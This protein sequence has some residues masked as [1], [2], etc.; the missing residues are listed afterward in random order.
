V[1][2]STP[3]GAELAGRRLPQAQ[4][5]AWLSGARRAAPWPAGL[6]LLAFAADAATK[7]WAQ[8]ALR[9][10][11]QVA[12]AG[13]LVRLQLVV[14]HGASFGIAARYG[15]VIAVAS[16]AAV[17]A[18]GLWT[19][20]SSGAVRFG[21]ALAAGGA[22]GNLTDRLADPPGPLRGGVIDWLHV[23]FYGP[24]FNLADLCLRGG[25]LIALGAW[26]RRE[27]SR[28]RPADPVADS[29]AKPPP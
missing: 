9:D 15:P 12:F 7:A 13:G 6:A 23:A 29:T 14:N 3:G 17:L 24:V 20:T 8:S 26:L 25:L 16:T 10:G 18:L 22:A 21:A 27:R 1:R 5:H 4:R 11:H 28:S 2:T 19:V